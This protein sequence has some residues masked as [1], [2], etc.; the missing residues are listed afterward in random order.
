VPLRFEWDRAKADANELKH[1]I[2]LDEASTAFGDAL[3]RTIPDPL[4]SYGEERFI[5]VG[6]TYRGNLVVAVHVEHEDG[7]IRL[8]S[9][10]QATGPERRDYEEP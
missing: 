2:P 7:T 8:I 6:E 3:S 10:R 9:A 1:G 5:L 4:H